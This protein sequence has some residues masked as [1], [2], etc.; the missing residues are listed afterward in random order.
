LG[1]QAATVVVVTEEVVLMVV[2]VWSVKGLKKMKP[3]RDDHDPAGQHVKT[4]ATSLVGWPDPT[5]ATTARQP[6]KMQC[7]DRSG[8]TL[9]RSP[10]TGRGQ[11]PAL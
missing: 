7:P 6:P 2:V 10:E 9:P 4:R 5:P 8:E 3:G 11:L 1:G